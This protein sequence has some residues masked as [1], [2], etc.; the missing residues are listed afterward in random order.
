M[1]IDK[2]KI[3]FKMTEKYRYGPRKTV[4]KHLRMKTTFINLVLS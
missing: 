2:D 3:T 4:S 1:A